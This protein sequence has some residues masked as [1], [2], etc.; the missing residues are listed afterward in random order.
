[1]LKK[2]IAHLVLASFT[3]Y[4]ITI[5]TIAYADDTPPAD[6]RVVTIKKGDPAPF[7]GT[8]FNTPASARLMVDLEFTQATC[9]LETNRQLGL[10]RSDL[11]LKIDLCGARNEALM[12][13]HSE[14]LLIKNDQINF[15]EKQF[16]PRPWYQS[17]EFGIIVGVVLGISVTLGAG[18]ALGQINQ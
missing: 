17:T 11:Q 18:Y 9:N 2:V 16:K 10:L 6:E 12:L 15:L 5:P 14:I 8:L 7:S 13:R 3:L 1:M 4:S